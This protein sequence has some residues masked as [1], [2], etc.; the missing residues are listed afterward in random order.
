[1]VLVVVVVEGIKIIRVIAITRVF[2]VWLPIGGGLRRL[3]SWRS[4]G[5]AMAVKEVASTEDANRE[6][7][8]GSVGAGGV[9]GEGG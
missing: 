6:L 8:A 4:G 1:M 7:P 5:S 3:A 2:G 9:A